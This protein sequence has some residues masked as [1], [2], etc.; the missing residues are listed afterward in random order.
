MEGRGEKKNAQDGSLEEL[1]PRLEQ[2]DE[3]LTEEGND[4]SG[5]QD[6]Y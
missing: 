6:G 1:W 4:R 3:A 5:K 2:V